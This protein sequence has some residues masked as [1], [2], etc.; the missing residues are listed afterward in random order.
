[1][2]PLTYSDADPGW[3]ASGSGG[4]IENLGGI[5]GA[6]LLTFSSLWWFRPYLVP[7]FARLPRCVL[8]LAE[9][10]TA[11]GLQFALRCWLLLLVGRQHRER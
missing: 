3:S 1:M 10:T 6:F 2:A 5:T 7:V 4:A 8:L 9:T 11:S